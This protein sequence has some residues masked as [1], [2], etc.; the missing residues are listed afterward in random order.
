MAGVARF[1]PAKGWLQQ[2]N[3]TLDQIVLVET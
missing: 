3:P 2:P 1:D